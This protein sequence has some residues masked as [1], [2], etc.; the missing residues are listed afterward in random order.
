MTVSTD[1]SRVLSY[2]L[3]VHVTSIESFV[4]L[5]CGRSRLMFVEQTTRSLDGDDI[6]KSAFS[7]VLG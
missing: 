4:T 7:N 2:K 3:V 5:D 6:H 1:V